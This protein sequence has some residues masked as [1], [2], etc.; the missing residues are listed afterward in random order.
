[1]ALRALHLFRGF[2]LDQLTALIYMMA[3]IAFL[4]LGRIIVLI[5]GK[6]NRRPGLDDQGTV[7]DIYHILLGMGCET[8]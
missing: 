3:L 1:M 7:I 8:D 6:L 2:I 5:V 4:D